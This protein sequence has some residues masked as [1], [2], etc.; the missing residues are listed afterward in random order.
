MLFIKICYFVHDVNNFLPSSSLITQQ[1]TFLFQFCIKKNLI[2]TFV[3]SASL[4]LLATHF[5]HDIHSNCLSLDLPSR[6]FQCFY[7]FS[8]HTF[9][10]AWVP[11]MAHSFST[12]FPV[13]T[14]NTVV[15][16]HL[17]KISYILWSWSFI[18]YGHRSP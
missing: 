3:L 18:C 15:A 7:R 5:L 10:I 8:K 1:N 2:H 6:V 13:R 14:T 4:P 11:F 17:V 16:T 12:F 9:L